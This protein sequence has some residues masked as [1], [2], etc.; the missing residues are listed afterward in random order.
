MRLHTECASEFPDAPGAILSVNCQR[1][2]QRLSLRVR[3]LRAK[4][5]R[6]LECI[7]RNPFCCLR[8]DTAGQCVIHRCCQR[9]DVR[10]SALFPV[11][12]VLL[13]GRKAGCQDDIQA[14]TLFAKILPC[15]A[16][17]HKCNCS[18]ISDQQI[19]RFDIP[20]DNPFAMDTL[21]CC[22]HRLE[23]AHNLIPT[24]RT[25]TVQ[26]VL[27]TTPTYVLHCKIGGI[28]FLKKS[29]DMGNSIILIKF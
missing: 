2:Q 18:I 15:S 10:E 6:R 3:Q 9:I 7:M 24:Q 26:I 11:S 1:V 22:Q 13:Q 20:M 8:R 19:L 28:V 29:I 21:Q 27:E 14:A 12:A 4:L 16:K 5:T 25:V 23:K 17:V